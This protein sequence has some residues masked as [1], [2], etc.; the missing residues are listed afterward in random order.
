MIEKL[1]I[2]F[3]EIISYIIGVIGIVTAVFGAFVGAK[4]EMWCVYFILLAT[5]SLLAFIWGWNLKIK[6]SYKEKKKELQHDIEEANNQI[7][8]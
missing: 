1:K 8:F 5:E 7:V 4:N 2:H 3:G 6:Y